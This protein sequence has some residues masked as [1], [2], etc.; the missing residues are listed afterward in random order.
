MIPVLKLIVGF[1]IGKLSARFFID[2]HYGLGVGLTIAIVGT[3][4]ACALIDRSFGNG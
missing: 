1:M 4:I 3:L 2:G